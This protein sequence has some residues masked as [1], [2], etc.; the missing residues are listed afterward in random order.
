[1][2][3]FDERRLSRSKGLIG[4]A[5]LGPALLLYFSFILYPVC[6]TIYNS[7]FTLSGPDTQR[8]V[9]LQNFLQIFGNDDVIWRAV[10]HSLIWGFAAAFLEAPLGFLLAL[11]LY[12]KIPGQRILR[13]AWFA[14][15][16]LSYVVVG[17]IWMWIFNNDWG[18]INL[19]LHA[20]G[21]GSLARPWLGDLSTVLPALILVTTWMSVGFS[22]VVLL[23][24]IGSIPPTLI[25]A[26][27]IDGASSARITVWIILPLVRPTMVNLMVLSFIAKMK[28]FA[29]VWIM[30]GGGPLWTTETVS[31]YVIKRAFYWKT[32]DL[33]Y[34]SAVATLWFFVILI[35]TVVLLRLGNR[36]QTIEF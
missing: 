2:S 25:E 30:T 16:L 29:L 24:A 12:S 27:R 35:A 13:I 4:A 21:L 17:P 9:G 28:Q 15:M 10:E 5:F 23:A 3:Q 20:V 19:I 8:F 7:F 36:R 26:A 11:A 18:A 31:T 33:G 34:P 6:R 22:M 32:F 14:P 1:M